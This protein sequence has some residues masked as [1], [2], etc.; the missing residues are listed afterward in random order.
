MAG[1]L[2]AY[3]LDKCDVVAVFF[4]PGAKLDLIA[5]VGNIPNKQSQHISI[6][7]SSNTSE[8]DGLSSIGPL[9]FVQKRGVTR[10]KYQYCL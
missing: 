7:L 6:L 2:I 1:Y 3:H 10:Q 8:S 4:K 5:G 9:T